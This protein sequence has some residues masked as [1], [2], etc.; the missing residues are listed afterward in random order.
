MST[1]LIATDAGPADD[2]LLKVTPPRVP[3]HLVIRSRLLSGNESLRDHPVI[4]VQAPAGF[5]KT[6]LLAQ[7]RREPG[8]PGGWRNARTARNA[9]SRR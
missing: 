5:G 1:T 4:L 6:S 2:L 7:W 8:S 9:W 3:R